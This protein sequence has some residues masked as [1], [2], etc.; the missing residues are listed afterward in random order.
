MLLD[1]HT[2]CYYFLARKA[3]LIVA[4]VH[5]VGHQQQNPPTASLTPTGSL[6]P[7]GSVPPNVSLTGNKS[8]WH[9]LVAATI[10]VVVI[11]LWQAPYGAL[12]CMLLITML[13]NYS[14]VSP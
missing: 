5:F 7:I 1:R 6:P 12:M 3:V 14:I 10:V 8:K 4:V 2:H 13:Y 9:M 11:L